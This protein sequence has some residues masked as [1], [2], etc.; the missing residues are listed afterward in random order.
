MGRREMKF[1][2]K[3][4]LIMLGIC[5]A[6]ICFAAICFA[7]GCSSDPVIIP[8]KTT[9]NAVML[10]L[11]TKLAEPG[12]HTSSYGWLFW[13]APLATILLMWGWRNL[14]KKPLD[15]IEKEPDSLK[16]QTKIDDNP[17]T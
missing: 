10:E 7:A 1:I 15:C 13:Y 12:V 16:I 2:T 11:K 14:I 6:A 5:F 8:N 17:E 4:P 3:I 9:D